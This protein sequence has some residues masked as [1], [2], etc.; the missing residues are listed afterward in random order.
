MFEA[1]EEELEERMNTR[2]PQEKQRSTKVVPKPTATP[3][4][5][6]RPVATPAHAAPCEPPAP[7]S[8]NPAARKRVKG[9]TPDPEHAKSKD[10]ELEELR[11]VGLGWLELELNFVAK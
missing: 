3:V 10:D 8:G 2:K 6:P 11:K 5:T 4:A 1:T 9:K 7:S